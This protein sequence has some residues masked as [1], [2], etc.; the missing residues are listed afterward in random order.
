MQVGP[1]RGERHQQPHQ[2]PATA[3]VLLQNPEGQRVKQD[4]KDMRPR[5]VVNAGRAHRRHGSA[6]PDPQAA[7]ARAAMRAISAIAASARTGPPAPQPPPA[8]AIARSPRTPRRRAIPTRTTALART[9]EGERIGGRDVARLQHQFAGADMP[10]GIAIAQ[11]RLEAARMSE[12][13]HQQRHKK[14]VEQRRHK[15]PEEQAA[16]RGYWY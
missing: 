8:R 14:H 2:A 11:Q 7:A 13:R 15:Q 1:Q 6:Q 16:G 4:R 10:A 5:Q 3:T 12:C 9:A